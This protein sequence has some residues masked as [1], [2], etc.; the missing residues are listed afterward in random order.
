[1]RLPETGVASSLGVPASLLPTDSRPWSGQPAAAE[2]V[3]LHCSMTRCA[4]FDALDEDSVYIHGG[5][6]IQSEPWILV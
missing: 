2:F 6:L 3:S 1:M 5:D 4:D